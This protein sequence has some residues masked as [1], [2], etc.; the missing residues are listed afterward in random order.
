MGT[1][2]FTQGNSFHDH[3]NNE[4]SETMFILDRIMKQIMAYPN[5]E[6]H[7]VDKR[8]QFVHM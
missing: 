8:M 5:T 3:F 7:E 2:R 4:I 1:G 6:C